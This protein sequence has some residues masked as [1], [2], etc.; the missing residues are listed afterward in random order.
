MGRPAIIVPITGAVAHEQL[1]NARS[2]EVSGAA[3]VI[4]EADLTAETLARRI[5]ALMDDPVVLTQ[6]AKAAHH[7]A[8]AMG[9]LD[10]AAKLADF[11]ETSLYSGLSK[12]VFNERAR[13]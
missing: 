10:A 9:T 5:E 7:Q 12:E 6:A 11:V 2:F 8:E 4:A 1:A 13:N 3:W